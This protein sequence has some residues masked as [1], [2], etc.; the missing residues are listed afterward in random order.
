MD[1]HIGFILK[2]ANRHGGFKWYRE[3]KILATLVNWDLALQV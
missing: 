1:M 3:S 2:S